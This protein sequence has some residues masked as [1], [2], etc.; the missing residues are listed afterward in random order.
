MA[1]NCIMSISTDQTICI[2]GL[3]KNENSILEESKEKND[4]KK[5]KKKKF[6]NKF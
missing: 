4:G 2:L 1:K 6:L 3:G 5:N